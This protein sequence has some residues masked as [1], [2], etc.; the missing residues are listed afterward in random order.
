VHPLIFDP[1]RVYHFTKAH[2][3]WGLIFWRY[4]RM[5][6]RIWKDPA[7]KN[8]SDEAMRLPAGV[9]EMTR[10][11]NCSPT[12]YRTPTAPERASAAA[13]SISAE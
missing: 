8:F 7:A 12:R 3:Q 9:D 11:S 10:S 4:Y 2:L 6:K 13:A 5:M 1:W